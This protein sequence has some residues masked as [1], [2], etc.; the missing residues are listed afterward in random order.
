[1]EHCGWFEDGISEACRPDIA[2]A[3]ASFGVDGREAGL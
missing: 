1:M 2:E 3:D